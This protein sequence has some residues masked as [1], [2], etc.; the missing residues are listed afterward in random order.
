MMRSSTRRD[1][2]V[3]A[4]YRNWRHIHETFHIDLAIAQAPERLCNQPW[5]KALKLEITQRARAIRDA[6]RVAA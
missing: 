4:L 6:E 1:F 2:V 3:G 5:Q